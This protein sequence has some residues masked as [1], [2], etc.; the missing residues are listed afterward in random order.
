EPTLER[1]RNAGFSAL[2]V[3][4]D[5]SV[6]GLRERDYRNGMR[7]LMGRNVLAKIPYLSQM[8]IR[9]GWTTSFLLDGGLRT[10]P[11]VIVPNQGPLGLQDVASA[12]AS[13]TV[14]WEDFRWIRE[15]WKGPIVAKGVL[16]GDDASRFGCR[17]MC[18]CS[19]Q[20]RRPATRLRFIFIKRTWRS[21]GGSWCTS[22]S[23]DGRW[24][25][26]G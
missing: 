2:F 9:P 14:T 8:V 5:T 1:A 19:F 26:A 7:A 3:T 24:N 18:G 23:S 15:I 16:T 6:A 11:N 13:S 4:I 21:S 25:S 17:G 22:R 20:P 12:L 10:L